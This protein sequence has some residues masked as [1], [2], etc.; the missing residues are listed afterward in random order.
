MS[1]VIHSSIS[2][3]GLLT[4]DNR[5]LRPMIPALLFDGQRARDVKDFR[6]RLV[7]LVTEGVYR[8]PM[9]EPC[10]GWSDMAGCPGHEKVTP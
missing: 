10:E 8:L 7:Q 3:T 2:V 4:W 6:S 5:D 1:R 9:G